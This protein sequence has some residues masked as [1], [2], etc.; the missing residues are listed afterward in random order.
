METEEET[1][2]PRQELERDET[3]LG[4]VLFR[5]ELKIDSIGAI[6]E[7][8]RGSIEPVMVTGD[9]IWTGLHVAEQ[10]GLIPKSSSLN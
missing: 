5:N 10:V 7:M 9:N 6:R 4:F 1:Q 8:K 2:R 3:F